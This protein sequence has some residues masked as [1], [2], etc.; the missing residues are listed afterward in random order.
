VIGYQYDAADTTLVSTKDGLILARAWHLHCNQSHD[1]CKSRQGA[2]RQLPTRLLY[3][4]D[5][6]IKLCLSSEVKPN[7]E[8]FTLSHCWGATVFTTLLSSN[9]AEF[10]E[11]ISPAALSTTFRDA[12]YVT[13]FFGCQYLWIDSLCI[14]QNNAKDWEKEA[15]LMASVYSNSALTR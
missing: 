13:R 1:L 9:I 8:Y 11:Q 2:T 10:Q 7:F 3:V 5:N 12:V 15:S 14:V 6:Q 4:G